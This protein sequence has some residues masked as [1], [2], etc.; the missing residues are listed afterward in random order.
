MGIAEDL[1]PI[2]RKPGGNFHRAI[3]LTVENGNV[4]DVMIRAEIDDGVQR[5]VPVCGT[6]VARRGGHR[7]GRVEN[8]I[9]HEFL[10]VDK[11]FH[12]GGRRFVD[13]HRSVQVQFVGREAF[14][15]DEFDVGGRQRVVVDSNLVNESGEGGSIVRIED[16]E[17]EVG[18]GVW[19][20]GEGGLPQILQLPV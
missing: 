14:L 3:V 17:M 6:I 10:L 4:G 13:D 19:D 16:A 20:G 1:G 18:R 11:R 2:K 9:T 7:I 5:V 12:I 15:A 8:G